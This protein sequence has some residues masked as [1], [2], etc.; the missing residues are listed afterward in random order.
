ME[1]YHTLFPVWEDC[2]LLFLGVQ[3]AGEGEAGWEGA[4]ALRHALYQL[5]QV[6]DRLQV[7]DLGNLKGRSTLEGTC[8]ALT[9]V[10][11]LIFRAGKTAIILGGSPAL[12]LGTYRAYEGLRS[13]LEYVHIDAALRLQE[14]PDFLSAQSY[15]HHIL[16][17]RGGYLF[18]FSHLGYQR[19]L[20]PAVHLDWLRQQH[21]LALR[22]GDLTG[23]LEEAEPVLRC[24]DMVSF[25]LS[26]I[27]RSEVPA[28]WG[29][30]PGGFSV[31]EACRLARY[32]GLGYRVSAFHLAGYQPEDE[33]RHQTADVAAMLAWYFV[34][35]RHHRWNDYPTPD[36]SNLRRYAVRLHASVDHID[37]FQHTGTGRWWMEV[38]HPDHLEKRSPE[39]TLLVPCS[40]SDYEFAKTD[41]IPE[42]WWLVYAR[43][44]Q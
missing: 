35:G 15:N 37:F 40:E 2:D 26:A 42:R 10:L 36:R 14:Q 3:D 43:L 29:A 7:A 32:A 8:E 44:G 25:D 4:A 11:N 20:V 38:P 28:A 13:D 1:A 34:E 17:D 23:R 39:H 27:Q 22:Y 9:Y 33:Q 31:L 21:Y 16:T 6:G 18:G 5:A 30:M 41:D 19:Y 12:A 24:A